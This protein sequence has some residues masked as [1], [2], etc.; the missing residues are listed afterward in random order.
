[1]RAASDASIPAW[2]RRWDDAVARRTDT[3][4]VAA[5][6]VWTGRELLGLADRIS[7]ALRTFDDGAE[8]RVVVALPSD[9]PLIAALIACTTTG[10]AIA[11]MAAD[12]NIGAAL[13][14]VAGRAVLT[15]VPREIA[16]VQWQ[17]VAHGIVLGT[18]SATSATPASSASAEGRWI[19]STSGSSGEPRW[20]ACSDAAIERV[21]TSHRAALGGGTARILSVLPWHHAFGLVLDL[22]LGL[23]DAALIVRESSGGRDAASMVQTARA[24]EL[25]RLNAVP[26]TISRL[27]AHPDGR[28]LL[29]SFTSGIVGGAP[30]SARLASALHGTRLRVGYGQTEA[31]P[32]I[33][34]GAP[35]EFRERWIGRALGCDVT[36]IDDRLHF[37]GVNAPVGRWERG[38]FVPNTNRS[39]WQDTGDVVSADADGWRF[40][41]RASDDFKLS[42]GRWVAA[43]RLEAAIRAATGAEDVLLW[44][45]DGEVISCAVT[46]PSTFDESAARSALGPL[47]ARVDVVHRVPTSAWSRTP[48]GELDRRRPPT[49]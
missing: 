26:A 15:D 7:E 31:A 46:A 34:L 3:V 22:L 33:T 44:S 6:R 35:G 8:T 17:T 16:G 42:N 45:T 39:G 1:M 12:G 32:G 21:L 48:K 19:L 11:P 29:A 14:A 4:L 25:T 5:G 27:L 24:F 23:F 37:R 28:E 49:L 47:A 30:I 40:E 13:D 36:S 2:R 20:I 10:C 41:G 9:A 18:R 38:V 43:A